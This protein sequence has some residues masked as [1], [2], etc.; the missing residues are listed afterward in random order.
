MLKKKTVK[1]ILDDDDSSDHVREQWW[2]DPW[3][4]GWPGDRKGD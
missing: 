3:N 1:K 2:N 4:M